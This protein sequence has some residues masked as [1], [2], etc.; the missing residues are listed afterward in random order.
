MFTDKEEYQEYLE[1]QKVELSNLDEANYLQRAENGEIII[2]K[3]D[4]NISAIDVERYTNC[5]NWIL[6]KDN[7]TM[8]L[9]K[10][11]FGDIYR[12]LDKKQYDI[13]LYNNILLPQI[14]KQLQCETAMYYLVKSGK[15]KNSPKQILTIDFK[16]PNEGIIHGEKILEEVNGDINELNIQDLTR[17]THKY[18][19]KKNIK[20]RDIDI[21]EK[22]F[23]KQ[24]FYN[25]FV[26]Q[27]DENNHNWGILLNEKETRAR[28][29]PIYDVDC[30]C[31]I[32]TLGK[33]VRTTNDGSKYN[34]KSFLDDYG[35]NQWFDTYI[36]EV[37]E[38][39]DIEK[40]IEGAKKETG[41]SIPTKIQDH[42][43]TFFGE[44]FYE[45][46]SAYKEYMT[47]EENKDVIR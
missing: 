36:K 6:L 42:Y 33:H 8:A 41:I 2:N 28:I 14:A 24:S 44:R 3:K 11:P 47:K 12:Q 18:L 26:K 40:A 21:I 13:S 31:D 37:I 30:C 10:R 4:F 17:E 27:A 35:T 29:A 9:I 32:S 34:L 39:F 38:E 46:K 45:L 23:I 16:K 20:S 1:K 15:S 22:E 19:E 7:K 43:K 5:I 25:R